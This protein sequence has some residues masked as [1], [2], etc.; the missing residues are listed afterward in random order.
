MKTSIHPRCLI[1]ENA[2]RIRE[3]HER[4][5]AAH[6][7]RKA[8]AEA[9]KEWSRACH[10][11]HQEY[12]GLAFPGGWDAALRRLKSGEC[13]DVEAALAF[14]EVRP[15]FFRS[16]YIWKKLSRLLSHVPLTKVQQ[17]RYTQV[18]IEERMRRQG[19]KP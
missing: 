12:D 6:K 17:E 10:V 3:L 19:R 13:C 16:Q 2:R 4:V 8:G 11:F 7:L 18:R 14:L 1:Q 15:Y 9:Q 5:H